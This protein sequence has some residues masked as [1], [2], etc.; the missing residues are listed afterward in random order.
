[1]KVRK[2]RS[3]VRSL[4]VGCSGGCM[5]K[6]LPHESAEGMRLKE[7]EDELA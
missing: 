3:R 7:V 2:E 6:Y 5:T 1:M 4:A